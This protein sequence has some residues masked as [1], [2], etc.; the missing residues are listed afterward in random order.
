MS[1][2]IARENTINLEQNYMDPGE[3]APVKD[4]KEPLLVMAAGWPV[5]LLREYGV[6]A[7]IGTEAVAAA[8]VT[9]PALYAILS[10]LRA[11]LLVEGVDGCAGF[12]GVAGMAAAAS[13]SGIF[14]SAAV[15]VLSVLG[16][17]MPTAVVSTRGGENTSGF[18]AAN[19]AVLGK[20]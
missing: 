3:L 13:W 19:C 6:P 4:A 5:G 10:V 11:V 17:A 18:A 12:L 2:A 9:E 16:M 8:L 20:I 14:D 7:A 1:L 15:G